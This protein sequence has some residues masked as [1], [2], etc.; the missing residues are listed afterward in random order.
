[1]IYKLL[2]FLLT[3]IYISPN[4]NRAQAFS[5]LSPNDPSSYSRPDQAIIKHVDLK[6]HVHFKNKVLSGSALLNFEALQ[7]ID[8]VILD[9]SSQVIEAVETGNG[10]ALTY[11]IDGEIP[12]IGSRLTIQLPQIISPNEKFAIRIQYTTAP[13]AS[14][15]QW[16]DPSQ[17]SGKQYPYLFS[18]SSPIHARSILPCQD[19]PSVKFTYDAEITAPEPFT[20]LMS[21]LTKERHTNRTIFYQPVPIPS[22]LLA[23]AVGV[24]ESR[25]IGPRTTIWTEKA[26][27]EKS[28]WEFSETES[29]LQAAE[30]FCGPYVWT[31]YDLLVLP[32]SF[33][34]GGM[35]NP[36]LSFVTPTLLAGDRSL[37][38]VIVHEIVHSWTGNLVTQ[39]NFEHFW[40][41]ESFTVFLER[42][43]AASLIA[44]PTEARKERDFHSLL[45][46]QELKD[47]VNKLGVD[48]P[49]TK[50]VL[51]LTGVH[52][53][54]A[55]SIVPYEKGS[56][57]LRYLED[58]VGFE[59]FEVFIRSYIN[60]FEKKSLDTDEFKA[61]LLDYFKHAQ[62]TLAQVDWD[63]W[64]YGTGMPPIIPN[65]DTSM[66]TAVTNLLEKISPAMDFS[67]SD[68][69]G[70]TVHQLI[71]LMQE[72]LDR[73]PLPVDRLEALGTSYGF[74]DSNNSEIRY[75]WLRLCCKSKN[76]VRLPEVLD[77]VN[78]VGRMKYVRPL[79]SDMFAWEEVRAQAVDN[80]LRHERFMM[81]V[82]AFNV[83]KD[84]HLDDTQS[85]LH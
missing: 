24:L 64:L 22:N 71:N 9:V 36:C 38:N 32:P 75:R 67:P 55:F 81:H 37:A 34:Y 60:H 16:L 14:A 56:L 30:K 21:A 51:N 46:L 26:E 19:S 35:E 5:A 18:Q 80:F 31:R 82:T 72:L 59:S 48:S 57:F 50:L 76:L 47:G 4:P 7:E 39:K 49:F 3:L 74:T 12:N 11:T 6:L 73:A 10:A 42:K 54:E 13:T 69:S 29:Y 28:A 85:Y 43:I 70:F 25:D 79:Y 61:F 40:L 84:L 45:G 1:M 58:L 77:F 8:S 20:I 63:K 66:T 2:W 41:K 65:Y 53:D 83:R 44:D 68:V 15:L 62:D 52:P 78:S 33:P 27:I 23:I 17:T